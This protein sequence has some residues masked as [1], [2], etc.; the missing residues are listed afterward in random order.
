MHKPAIRPESVLTGK[1]SCRNLFAEG[2]YVE[3]ETVMEEF[4]DR[5]RKKV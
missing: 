3:G 4:V 5:I 1:F 2:R